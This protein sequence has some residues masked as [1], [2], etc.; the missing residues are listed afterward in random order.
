MTT[1]AKPG[2][3]VAVHTGYLEK[4]TPLGTWAKKFVTINGQTFTLS[5]TEGGPALQSFEMINVL[6]AENGDP[7]LI[8]FKGASE[9]AVL[10]GER[11]TVDQWYE[12]C[13]TTLEAAGKLRPRNV[14]LPLIDPRFN[15]KFA[16]VPAEFRVRF[17]SLE[18]AV[19]YWFGLVKKYNAPSKLTG[20]FGTEERVVFVS[21]KALY[22]T[23]PDSELTRCIKVFDMKSLFSN[24]KTKKPG[25]EAFLIIKMEAP[26]YDL[27]FAHP[28]VE[29]LI[30]V[31]QTLYPILSKGQPLPLH[32]AMT[33]TDSGIQLQLSRPEGFK[34][35]MIVPTSKILLKR[36]L[37]DYAAKNGLQ[38]TPS[39]AVVKITNP[40][41]AAKNEESA[42]EAKKPETDFL[43]IFLT[44]I[45][46]EALVQP[47][48][49]Q[50]VDF[51]VLEVME[52]DDYRNFGVLPDQA[53]VIRQKISDDEFI[54]KLRRGSAPPSSAAAA[55]APA[56]A[57]PAPSKLQ[58]N[59]LA[60]GGTRTSAPAALQNLSVLRAGGKVAITLSD[61]DNDDLNVGGAN[62]VPAKKA[63]ISFADLDLDDLDLP[64]NS[65]KSF[66]MKMAL[67]EDDLD[68]PP[69]KTSS[70]KPEIGL[71][72][73]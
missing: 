22:V 27:Y 53:R 10:R 5:E 44:A 67:D 72:E 4:K 65:N 6:Q 3:S 36:A 32:S 54:A 33:P 14:G 38:L 7:Q 63:P 47:L 68:L 26:E 51:E 60:P 35:S 12:L 29:T 40:P 21:D 48:K 24:L 37:D 55:P 11:A 58:S 50:M 25:E 59:P 28:D 17:T 2:D 46:L 70:T 57:V 73:I 16:D 49:K 1:A 56:P 18:T 41:P 52:E 43:T 31:L 69:V 9:F 39:G 30:I 62:P 61:D 13:R 64:G 45:G 15:L 34:V 42:V 19:I 23:K 8:T 20:K 66:D 71:D